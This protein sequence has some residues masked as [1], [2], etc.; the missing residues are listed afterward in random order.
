MHECALPE[1]QTDQLSVKDDGDVDFDNPLF[2]TEADL[3]VDPTS[4]AAPGFDEAQLAELD[5]ASAEIFVP[6]SATA[7]YVNYRQFLHDLC[8][9][10]ADVD[11]E[12]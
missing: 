9:R 10:V 11:R 1:L 2:P 4:M 3:P 6:R 8:E 7:E 12:R 5:A